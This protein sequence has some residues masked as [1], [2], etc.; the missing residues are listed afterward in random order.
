[1]YAYRQKK[2][3]K[4]W[5]RIPR[6]GYRGCRAHAGGYVISR[7]VTSPRGLSACGDRGR[8]Y[9]R[10]HYCVQVGLSLA[11]KRVYFRSTRGPISS[12]TF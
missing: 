2:N 6:S 8:I 4:G 9:S 5:N 11:Q 7:G 1:M 10:P 3:M 12:N